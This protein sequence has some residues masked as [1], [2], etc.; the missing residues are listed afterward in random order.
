KSGEIYEEG[1]AATL[2]DGVDAFSLTG[3]A[4]RPPLPGLLPADLRRYYGIVVPPNVLLNLLDDHVVILTLHAEAP[5][6]TRVVCDWLFHPSALAAP[7]FDPS[8]TVAIFDLVNRQDWEV[9]EQVQ[10]SMTSRAYR[11]GGVYVPT[12]RHIR[13]FCD[14]ILEKLDWPA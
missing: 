7:D 11:S 1:D 3:K 14:F 13:A 6:R 9:C 2:A 4:S 12:E 10:L 5:D 8:D